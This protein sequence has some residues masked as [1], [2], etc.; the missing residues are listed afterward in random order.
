M[1]GDK[2][3]KVEINAYD[4]SLIN[5]AKDNGSINAVQNNRNDKSNNFKENNIRF[6]NNKKQDYIKIWNSRLF[7][8]ADNDEN[9]LTLA[10]V[11]IVPDYEMYKK[12]EGIKFSDND[13]LDQVIEKFIKYDRTSTMLITGVPGIGKSSITAW[14]ANKYKKDNRVIILRFGVWESEELEN[15]LLKA[16]YSKLECKKSDLEYKILVLD[17]FDEIKL[18]NIRGSILNTFLSDIKD[19]RNFKCIITSR[20]TY[21]DSDNFQ[22]ALEVKQ[23]DIQKVENFYALIKGEKLRDLEKIKDNLE[24]LGIPVILYLS[25][26]SGVNISENPTKPE[27]YDKIFAAKGGIFDKFSFKDPGYDIGNQVL[28]NSENIKQ[29][30]NFLRKIA[31]K[32]FEKGKLILLEGEYQ[33]PTLVINKKTVNIL[34]FPIKHLFESVTNIEFVHKSICEYF[35]ADCIFIC[36]YETINEYV[37]NLAGVLGYLL[38]SKVLS[39]EILEFL[40]Y[41]IKKYLNNK[42][43]FVN[44]AFSLMLKYGMTYHTKEHYKNVVECEMCVFANM[45]EILHSWEIDRFVFEKQ[46]E[47]YIKRNGSMKINLRNVDLSKADLRKVDLS[48]ADLSGADLSKAD[49]SGANLSESNLIN[50]NLDGA[51]LIGTNFTKAKLKKAY[52]VRANLENAIFVQADLNDASILLGNLSRSNLFGANLIGTDFRGMDLTK[53]DL[54]K[55]DLRR[56]NLNRTNL[57]KVDFHGAKVDDIKLDN[58]DITDA[59]FDEYQIIFLERKYNLNRVRVYI[60]TERGIISYKAYCNKRNM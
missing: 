15:G 59:I 60:R 56:A 50:T 58:A 1:E 47:K 42:F 30:L 52:L 39:D 7:L 16:I 44:N 19:Y 32:M 22:N 55:V 37:N 38:K 9:P 13:K 21:I 57:K 48:K 46:I 20:P 17:G 31:F 23:F 53:V 41:K 6:Q 36:M 26:M 2:V 54:R 43:V 18:L 35:V 28:R 33:I 4:G 5:L 14:I 12:I 10:N 34:D 27:M 51:I 3:V 29:Y 49:L 45:L 40:K 24:V 8:H 11:F 25:I